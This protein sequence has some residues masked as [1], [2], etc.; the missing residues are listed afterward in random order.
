V[1]AHVPGRDEE[2]REEY[3]CGQ[4]DLPAQEEHGPE[5]NEHRDQVADHVGEEIGERLLGSDH[6]IVKPADQRTGLSTGKKGQRH[7]LNVAK[8]FGP[9]IEDEPLTDDGG[10]APF[11]QG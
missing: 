9:H 7:L 8:D 5:H 4:C 2:H 1:P 3:Q 11:H 6:I 10:D